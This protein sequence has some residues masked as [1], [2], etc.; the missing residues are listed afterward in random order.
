ML[1]VRES[2]PFQRFTLAASVLF[3]VGSLIVFTDRS[4]GQ[5]AIDLSQNV[6]EFLITQNFG[7]TGDVLIY[8]SVPEWTGY[9]AGY[10]PVSVRV[11]PKRGGV[12]RSDGRLKVHF[13]NGQYF[14]ESGT[15]AVLELALEQGAPESRGEILTNMFDTQVVNIFASLNGQ[16]LGGQKV[17]AYNQLG[18]TGVSAEPS[19]VIF[20]KDVSR[21]DIRRKNAKEDFERTGRWFSRSEPKTV[22]MNQPIYADATKLPS[23][24][25]EFSVFHQI[26]ISSVELDALSEDAARALEN[27]ALAGGVL[28][29]DSVQTLSGVKRLFSINMAMAKSD[30]DLLSS[31]NKWGAGAQTNL[32]AYIQDVQPSDFDSTINLFPNTMWDQFHANCLTS[33]FS[34]NA[35]YYQ[36]PFTPPFFNSGDLNETLDLVSDSLVEGGMAWLDMQL[37]PLEISASRFREIYEV[38]V[39]EIRSA[40]E[41]AEGDLLGSD[42]TIP[43]GFGTIRLQQRARR[44]TAPLFRDLSSFAIDVPINRVQR[45]KEGI[46]DDFWGW[47]I[48]SVGRTPVIPFLVFVSAFAGLVVPG[49]LVWCNQHKRRVWIVVLMPLMAGAFTL[50]LFGY[51]VLKD[52]F[53][54]VCRLRSFAF[55]DS[56]G[57]G[58]VWSRQSYFA[59][60]IPYEG[61]VVGNETQMA[62]LALQS[63]KDWPGSQQYEVDGKQA[64]IGLLQPRVQSQF[65][66]T[67]P[68]DGLSLVGRSDEVDEV[69]NGK[70]I[71][72]NANFDW[73]VA[74]FMDANSRCFIA[75]QVARGQRA[76][77]VEMDADD[78]VRVLRRKY[79]S[80][81]TSPPADAPSA[82]QYTL[83]QFFRRQFNSF[84]ARVNNNGAIFEENFWAER[85][86]ITAKR[87]VANQSVAPFKLPPGSFMILSDQAPYLER[88]LPD[89]KEQDGLHGIMGTW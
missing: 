6:S 8:V 76:A 31:S 44:D 51:G 82:D 27:Y 54:S 72:N 81:A 45:F 48:P 23:N 26:S 36:Q 59:A 69:L 18:F 71:V 89:A 21:S 29:I 73:G 39:P 2:I 55:V 56:K 74:M 66:I 5:V 58:L 38:P 86:G 1:H 84:N 35:I 65:S 43:H 7:A 64:Y 60:R 85:V 28:V 75:E 10:S 30:S 15:Q 11:I 4:Q 67:H 33:G 57:D 52:G 22:G 13:A 25:L 62:P 78:G 88:C 16:R 83:N 34:G 37:M 49:L 41:I 50:A 17:Y 70:S 42:M 12:F 47:L 46:G 87:S 19:L 32:S 63:S 68:L 79:V 20:S 53:G 3:F 24:W 40:V 61:V 77:L 9:K 80:V 14:S